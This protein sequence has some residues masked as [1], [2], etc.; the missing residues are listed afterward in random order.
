MAL[1]GQAKAEYMRD[2]MR[3][4]RNGA[5]KP[6]ECSFCYEPRSND[7]LLVSDHEGTIFICD[8]CVSLASA[9]IAE[10]RRR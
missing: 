1:A 6:A 3:R 2:Y 9:K 10:V 8:V 5:A 7:R 4:K